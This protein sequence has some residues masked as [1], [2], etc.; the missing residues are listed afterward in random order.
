MSGDSFKPEEGGEAIKVINPDEGNTEIDAQPDSGDAMSADESKAREELESS[1]DDETTE[2]EIEPEQVEEDLQA[3][4]DE[5][6]PETQDEVT[7]EVSKPVWDGNPENLPEELEPTYKSML[8]G[9]HQKTRELAEEKKK[10]EELQTQLLLK[11]S[12]G[13]AEAKA[14]EGPPPLPTGDSITQE[15]WNSAVTEQNAW[16]AEQARL[17][18]LKELQESG[19]FASAEEVAVERQKRYVAEVTAK[20]AALPGYSKD[21]EDLML[22]TMANNAFWAHAPDSEEGMMELARVS[23]DAISAKGAQTVAATKAEAKIRKQATAASRA[24]PRVTTPKGASPEDVFAKDGFK[25]EN[26][27]MEYAEKIALESLGG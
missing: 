27:K 4:S 1:I 10:F 5:T 23:I 26:E 9:F 12:D 14:K 17:K 11:V 16:H 15:Q 24:T 21:A 8:Q 22:H 18:N 2:E 19:Q 13:P 6:E 25:N 7:E 3:E 20:V